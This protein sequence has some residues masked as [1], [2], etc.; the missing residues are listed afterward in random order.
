MFESLRSPKVE[1]VRNYYIKTKD[2]HQ[3]QGSV[4]RKDDT[5]PAL[6]HIF[7]LFTR[8]ADV[9]NMYCIDLSL[10]CEINIYIY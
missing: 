8:S 10:L 5:S 4:T 1:P 7:K 3:S 6:H 9:V 2:E